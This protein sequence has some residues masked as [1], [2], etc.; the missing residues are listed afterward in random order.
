VIF[1]QA[2]TAINTLEPELLCSN[3]FNWFR[4]EIT[5]GTSNALFG[6]Q[7]P[8]GKKKKTMFLEGGLM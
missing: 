2:E 5:S 1:A 8:F 3:L 4:H 7:N 6:P